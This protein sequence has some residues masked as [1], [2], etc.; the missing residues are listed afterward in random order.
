MRA[1]KRS[2][3]K[4]PLGHKTATL[5]VVGLPG[6]RPTDHRKP[7]GAS[8]THQFNAATAPSIQDTSRKPYRA[9]QLTTFGAVRDLTAGG[10]GGR[11]ELGAPGRGSHLSRR[12]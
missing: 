3:K 1:V 5:S 4:M 8:V 11:L 6:A 10:S 7:Q 12:G 9:P 2:A